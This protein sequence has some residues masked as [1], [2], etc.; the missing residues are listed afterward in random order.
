LSPTRE[1]HNKK[2]KTKDEIPRE[3]IKTYKKASKPVDNHMENVLR[4]GTGLTYSYN[5]VNLREYMTDAYA[6][7]TQL[8]NPTLVPNKDGK[9]YN[10]KL[11][12]K[13]EVQ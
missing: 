13:C 12:L 8:T 6:P 2:L 4:V 7:D 1:N 3:N 5:P 11:K 10:L 9:E